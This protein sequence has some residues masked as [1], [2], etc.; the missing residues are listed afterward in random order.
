M[1]PVTLAAI[2]ALFARIGNATFGGGDAITAVLQRELVHRRRWLSV[3]QYGLA[4]SLA[5][6][7]P[8]TGIL[9]FAA[10]TAWML[11]RAAGAVTAVLAISVPSSVVVV[12]L[13]W[14]FASLGGSRSAL[15]VLGAVLA[16][17]VGLMWAAAWLLIR[18]E[19]GPTHRVRSTVF[20]VSAFLA[21]AVWSV[22][23]IQVLAAA[24]VVG[25]V[26]TGREE[27]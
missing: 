25:F 16:A 19:L 11:R 13:T 5:K 24:A 2:A 21:L 4:Q 26:W 7:T 9:A 3:D 14:A 10:A 12:G 27:G 8:G 15:T 18:P 20:V 23:P 6:I 1:S 17:A 22:S